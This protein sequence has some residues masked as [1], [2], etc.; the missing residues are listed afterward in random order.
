MYPPYR[1]ERDNY[2]V[3]LAGGDAT[4]LL[5]LTRRITG[6]AVPKQFCPIVGASTLLEQTRRRIALEISQRRTFLVLNRKH[7]NHYEHHIGD[8]PESQLVIQSNT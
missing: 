1:M 5:P 8:L 2:A 6:R 3:I 7:E 4:R